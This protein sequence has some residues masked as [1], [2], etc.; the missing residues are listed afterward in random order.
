MDV[1]LT[2]LTQLVNEDPFGEEFDIIRDD[3]RKRIQENI[4]DIFV[5]VKV[6]GKKLT[7]VNSNSVALFERTKKWLVIFAII[8]LLVMLLTGIYLNKLLKKP[9]SQVVKATEEIRTGNLDYSINVKYSP[10]DDLGKLMRNFNIMSRRLSTMTS[11]MEQANIVLQEEKDNLDEASRHKNKFIRHLGHELRA[12][13]SSIMGFAELLSEGYYGDLTEKQEDYIRRIFKSSNHL[14]ELVNDLVDQAKLQAGV[15][16]L[17]LEKTDLKEF[18]SEI[19][20]SFEAKAE[21]EKL[22]LFFEAA[23][24]KDYEIFIDQKRMRQVIVNLVSNAFKFTPEGEKITLSIDRNDKN[25]VISV[26]D[27]G[28]GIDEKDQEVIFEEFRQVEG[29]HSQKGAG[30]GLPLSLQLV[31]M[32]KGDIKVESEIGKGADFKVLL[33]L[34]LKPEDVPEIEDEDKID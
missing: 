26:K 7:K 10:H 6:N 29:A 16:T 8:I 19:T 15:F 22:G 32:H 12:P 18:V 4:K 20:S 3:I 34:D 24:D 9:I 21:K 13:L 2:A 17:T 33:P 1:Q 28:I 31:K 30:L 27:T 23:S 11:R 14:L 25:F 5:L